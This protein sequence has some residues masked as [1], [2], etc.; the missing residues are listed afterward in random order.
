MKNVKARPQI[1]IRQAS[2]NE[3]YFVFKLQSG[4]IFMSK[5]FEDVEE[6]LSAAEKIKR[7]AAEE[8]CYLCKNG[9]TNQY[10][11]VFNVKKNCPIGQSSIYQDRP[12]MDSEIHYMKNNLG[13]AEIVDLTT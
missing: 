3:Y 8:S 11:F 9:V 4:G 6:A 12:S 5:F 13:E 2:E 7:R 10:Y 1:E